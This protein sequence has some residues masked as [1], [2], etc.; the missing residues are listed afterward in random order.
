M[1][2]P[3]HYTTMPRH[4]S[5][6][7]L[8]APKSLMRTVNSTY[9]LYALVPENHEVDLTVCTVTKDIFYETETFHCLSPT[10]ALLDITSAELLRVGG[11]SSER[12]PDGSYSRRSRLGAFVLLRAFGQATCALLDEYPSFPMK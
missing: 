4:I 1:T 12:G 9:N 8:F 5:V 3:M 6:T 10:C 11:E 2:L 7:R